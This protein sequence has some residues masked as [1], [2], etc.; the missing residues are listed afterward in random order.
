MSF[1][2]VP[3]MP[4]LVAKVAKRN[5]VR[6]KTEKFDLLF[7]TYFTFIFINH[8]KQHK[9]LNKPPV[10]TEWL[11]TV[12]IIT[13]FMC[14]RKVSSSI[15]FIFIFINSQGKQ[16]KMLRQLNIHSCSY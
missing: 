13:F 3:H 7:F 6:K 12:C 2:L 10:A 9:M 1:H 16:R 8:D 4:R 5:Y 15:C 11:Q 14:K